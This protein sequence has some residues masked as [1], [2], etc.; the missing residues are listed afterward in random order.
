M[1]GQSALFYPRSKGDDFQ[2]AYLHWESKF[3]P[4]VGQEQADDVDSGT[5]NSMSL[6]QRELL[7]LLLLSGLQ[8]WGICTLRDRADGWQFSTEGGERRHIEALWVGSQKDNPFGAR[9]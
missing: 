3:E 7:L 1:F 5:I 9:L 6:P 2:G 4:I 8:T